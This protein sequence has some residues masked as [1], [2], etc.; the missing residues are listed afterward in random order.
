MFEIMS[1]PVCKNV[2]GT[3]SMLAVEQNSVDCEFYFFLN[4][5]KNPWSTSLLMYHTVPRGSR[6]GL[7]F[8]ALPF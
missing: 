8:K 7:Q 6:F 1:F 5:D 3:V 4:C 2:E